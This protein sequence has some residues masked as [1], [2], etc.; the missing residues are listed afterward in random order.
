MKKLIIFAITTF[1]IIIG[2]LILIDYTQLPKNNENFVNCND[3][4]ECLYNEISKGNSAKIVINEE[5]QSLKIIEKS[6]IE[7]K[8]LEKKY[9][10]KMTILEMKQANP[11]ADSTSWSISEE[12]AETCPQ[13]INNLSKIESKTAICYTNS[14][15]ETKELAIKGLTNEFISKYNCNGELI[16]IVTDICTTNE[17]P[18]FPPGVWKPA[19]YLYP[20][21]EINARVSVDINGFITKS[22]PTYGIGWD[23]IAKPD[24]LIDNTYDYL[25]YEAQLKKLNLPDE[26]WI[27][28]TSEMENWFNVM[29]PRLGLNQK[30]TYQF[31][32]YWL[33][34]LINAEFYE[35]KILTKS[36][37]DNNMKL[38]VNPKPDNVIRLIFYFKPHNNKI[39]LDEPIIYSPKRRG[40]TVVEWGG[41]LDN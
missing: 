13:L 9:E 23:V 33:D 17:S 22:I 32:D 8:P 3:S 35:I 16:D 24:G 25:F 29:L 31:K 1:T 14:P 36:F 26:G 38:T 2:V 30:E 4:Y 18:D 15:E 6:L 27:I 37:L 19:I 39:V 21:T 41:I 20:E 12:I 34:K 10:V 28:K 40:F 7:V 5:V 11:A